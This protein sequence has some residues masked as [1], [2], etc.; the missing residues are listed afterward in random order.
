MR[1]VRATGSS[2]VS[3]TPV[4]GSLRTKVPPRVGIVQPTYGLDWTL[5]KDAQTAEEQVAEAHDIS[6]TLRTG[7]LRSVRRLCFGSSSSRA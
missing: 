1:L 3:W 2:P 6:D 4:V 5:A 7:S